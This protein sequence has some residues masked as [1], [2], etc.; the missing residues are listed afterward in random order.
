ME[1]SLL[2]KVVVWDT[3]NQREIYVE[4]DAESTVYDMKVKLMNI[5]GTPIEY[6]GLSTA[7]ERLEDKMML[8]EITGKGKGA[9]PSW[10][11]YIF[12]AA[13]PVINNMTTKEE[14]VRLDLT[15]VD[16]QGGC[17]DAGWVCCECCGMAAVCRPCECI[18]RCM[19][20]FAGCDL[21]EWNSVQCFCWR[22]YCCMTTEQ[23]EKATG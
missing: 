15:Y 7:N 18:S 13:P 20:V 10:S 11:S 2:K 16:V 1:E 5:S 23:E 12:G 21:G 4:A 9:P 14:M 3:A 17:P 6:L 8:S 22:C 19:C